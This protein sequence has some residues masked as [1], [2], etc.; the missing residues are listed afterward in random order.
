M[1]P[2]KKHAGESLEEAMAIRDEAVACQLHHVLTALQMGHVLPTFQ[3]SV[4][5][6]QALAR[7]VAA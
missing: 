5:V 3:Q 2:N 1:Q 4:V 6:Q 7:E